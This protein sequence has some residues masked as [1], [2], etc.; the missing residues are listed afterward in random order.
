MTLPPLKS[1]RKYCDAIAEAGGYAIAYT[2]IA[3]ALL[4]TLKLFHLVMK[5]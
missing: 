2:L 1:S 3:A 5:L 4:A